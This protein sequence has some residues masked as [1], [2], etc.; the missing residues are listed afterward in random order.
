MIS[1]LWE[2]GLPSSMVPILPVSGPVAT[3]TGGRRSGLLWA[4]VSVVMLLLTA[5]RSPFTVPAVEVGLFICSLCVTGM[6][7]WI[8]IAFWQVTQA[9]AV[10][11][12]HH[13]PAH[14]DQVPVPGGPP[15]A[16]RRAA[17]AGRGR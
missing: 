8:T 10:Q 11:S 15:H 14:R 9:Q 17:S 3:F 12:G 4:S 5:A 2:Y 6:A 13:H 1:S 16:A 7:S